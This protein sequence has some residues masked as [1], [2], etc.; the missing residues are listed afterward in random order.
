MFDDVDAKLAAQGVVWA[1]FLNAGQVCT[2]TERVYVHRRVHEDLQIGRHIEVVKQLETVEELDR[3][4][5]AAARVEIGV[6]PPPPDTKRQLVVA[7][8]HSHTEPHAHVAL[9]ER[10]AALRI[11]CTHEGV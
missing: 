9:Q 1:A 7:P 5:V 3:R 2:S 8:A 11:P 10:A 6:G 4:L